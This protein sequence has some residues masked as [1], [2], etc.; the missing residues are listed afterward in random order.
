MDRLADRLAI[1]ALNDDFAHFLDRGPVEAFVALFTEDV[2]YTNGAR[3]LV[4][5]DEMLAFFRARAQAGRVSRH[6]SSG[7]RIAFEGDDRAAGLSCW[8]TFAGEG[9]LPIRPAEPFNVADIA[10]VYRRTPEGWRIAERHITQVFVSDRIP[11]LPLRAP[12]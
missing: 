2:V 11:G 9:A 10:D 6:L 3:R 1:A 4:G 7:L 5:R 8:L 12:G